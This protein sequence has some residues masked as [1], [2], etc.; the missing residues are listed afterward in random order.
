MALNSAEKNIFRNKLVYLEKL[1]SGCQKYKY[2]EYTLKWE[3]RKCFNEVS[4]RM[5][6][7]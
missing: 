1:I 2:V 5:N 6:F 3:I 7:K 4:K